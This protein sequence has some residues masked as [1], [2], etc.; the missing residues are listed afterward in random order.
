MMSKRFLAIVLCLSMIICVFAGC[1]KEPEVHIIGPSETETS[2]VVSSED[3]SSNVASVPGPEDILSLLTQTVSQ[4]DGYKGEKYSISIPEWKY[5]Q[6]F[7][8]YLENTDVSPSTYASCVV[9]EYEV[10]KDELY[11]YI[12]EY[13]GTERKFYAGDTWDDTVTAFCQMCFGSCFDESIN[14]HYKMT[15]RLCF[16]RNLMARPANGVISDDD[17]NPIYLPDNFYLVFTKHTDN[18]YTYCKGYMV[19]FEDYKDVAMWFWDRSANRWYL[20]QIDDMSRKI[21]YTFK[22]K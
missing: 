13:D 4:T 22:Q 8:Y 21:S 10:V 16:T 19:H 14:S 15:D 1:K 7:D 2:E 20:N 9:R 11:F 18:P 3:T 6:T 5:T 12:G 17:P